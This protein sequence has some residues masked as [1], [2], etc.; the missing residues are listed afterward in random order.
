MH[1]PEVVS[2]SQWR[3]VAV[4]TN[5]TFI[6][7]T[8]CIPQPY[9]ENMTTLSSDTC[10]E[11]LKTHKHDKKEQE[12]IIG[13]LVM[14]IT[15]STCLRR[16]KLHKYCNKEKRYSLIKNIYYPMSQ[17]FLFIYKA[18]ENE[19]YQVN[20]VIC[21][22]WRDMYF[23]WLWSLYICHCPICQNYWC[24]E[25]EKK[26]LYVVKLSHRILNISLIIQVVVSSDSH[27]CLHV[28]FLKLW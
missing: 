8:R 15:C 2:S 11:S 18:G 19:M 14:K 5:C 4:R 6:W 21:I 20:E 25:R 16:N 17:H 10:S 12:L 3:H 24:L 9:Q 26:L 22:Y 23:S 7:I 13:T 1:A 28:D 27:R